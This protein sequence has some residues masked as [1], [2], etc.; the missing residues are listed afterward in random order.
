MIDDR[1]R[2][3]QFQYAIAVAKNSSLKERFSKAIRQLRSDGIIR[4]LK[5]KY[6][7]N[8][9]RN[10]PHEAN[11]NENLDRSTITDSIFAS[12]T[13][14]FSTNLS[15]E[16]HQQQSGRLKWFNNRIEPHDKVEDGDVELIKPRPDQFATRN[17]PRPE[18]PFVGRRNHRNGS[19]SSFLIKENAIVRSILLVLLFKIYMHISFS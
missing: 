14:R 9:N 5:D 19:D 3:F 1:R 18:R 11:F 6:W 12:N 10:C 8:Q 16:N 17:R 13:D 15:N 2:N 4:E 7:I